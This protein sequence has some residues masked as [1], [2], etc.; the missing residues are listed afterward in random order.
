MTRQKSFKTR[1]RERM[2]K[3]GESYTTA[4]QQ[5]I[6]KATSPGGSAPAD[7]QV[8]AVSGQRMSDEALARRTGKAW[9]EWFE[10]LDEWGASAQPHPEIARWLVEE[11]DVD[12]WWAQTIT[13]GFEQARGLRAPGQSSDGTFS[14]SAS[15]TVNVGADRAFDAF[16]D[17]TKRAEW[18]PD[19]SLT[20]T[21][22]NRPKSFRADWE[23]GSTR[24]VVWLSSKGE[25]KTQI[26]IQQEKLADADAAAEWKAYWRDRLAVLKSVLEG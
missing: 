6:D 18:L 9:D 21:T 26:A 22:V 13:V 7:S 2:D 23:D 17:D 4:R 19:V 12:G 14:A 24:L 25:S 5:L 20:P 10:L 11:Q 16:A 8:I 3:T 15:K 1:I